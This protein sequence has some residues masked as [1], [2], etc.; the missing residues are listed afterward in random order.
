MTDPPYSNDALAKYSKLIEATVSGNLATVKDLLQD[1]SIDIHTLIPTE[2]GNL[3]SAVVL[4]I[5]S[6]NEDM[7]EAFLNAPQ[8]DF[9]RNVGEFQ[10]KVFERANDYSFYTSDKWYCFNV[11]NYA[12][13]KENFKLAEE[14]INT[15]QCSWSGEDIVLAAHFYLRNSQAQKFMQLISIP[16]VEIMKNVSNDEKIHLLNLFQYFNVD[17]EEVFDACFPSI[18]EDYYFNFWKWFYT[19]NISR[20]WFEKLKRK[21]MLKHLNV[22]NSEKKSII[23]SVVSHSVE[24]AKILYDF[25]ADIHLN[26]NG[27]WS[28]ICEA[29]SNVSEYLQ[30]FPFTEDDF[31]EMFKSKDWY[32]KVSVTREIFKVY[33]DYKRLLTLENVVSNPLKHNCSIDWYFCLYYKQ[34]LGL[35]ADSQIWLEILAKLGINE[36]NY[37]IFNFESAVRNLSEQYEPEFTSFFESSKGKLLHLLIENE[38]TMLAIEFVE[39]FNVDWFTLDEE[40][41]SAFLKILIVPSQ[42]I[43]PFEV[44]SEPLFIQVKI[45]EGNRDFLHHPKLC[46]SNLALEIIDLVCRENNIDMF[47]PNPSTGETLLDRVLKQEHLNYHTSWALLSSLL[48]YKK[49]LSESEALI[50]FSKCDLNIFQAIYSFPSVFPANILEMRDDASG[51]LLAER[52]IR[53]GA[54][55]HSSLIISNAEFFYPLMEV[56]STTQSHHR[57]YINLLDVL[58]DM[59]DDKYFNFLKKDAMRARYSDE[60][61]LETAIESKN[62]KF[63]QFVIEELGISPNILIKREFPLKKLISGRYTDIKGQFFDYL[64]EKGAIVCIESIQ[65][66]FSDSL[67]PEWIDRLFQADYDLPLEKIQMIKRN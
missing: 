26:E 1:E 42:E 41:I 65:Y 19:L 7:I 59:D 16:N 2:D 25:G 15:R 50:F 49:I 39:T 55:L 34:E 48:M 35:Q 52:A 23:L 28:L 32:D 3:T 54:I 38:R 43:S 56:A 17:Y 44:G 46:P 4:A 22:L 33:P 36:Y 29:S 62:L 6:N 14:L 31:V 67:D 12:L 63:L 24:K 21:D 53:N 60:K 58:P 8:M 47:E 11:I 18:E 37:F 66:V 27:K 51:E 64:V 10:I 20:E 9:K 13:L 40:G 57:I 45:D 30:L 61:I 5:D